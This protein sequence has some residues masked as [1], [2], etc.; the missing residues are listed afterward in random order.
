MYQRHIS[1]WDGERKSRAIN[2]DLAAFRVLTSHER[3]QTGDI[4]ADGHHVG[5]Y[6]PGENGE[7]MT[8]SA[9]IPGKGNAAVHNRW[10]F[11]GTEEGTVIF[12]RY[13]GAP[14]E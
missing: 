2:S 8:I 6:S 1:R 14:K 10:G 4:V 3:P 11:R 12:R 9:A 7:D 13:V 5:I